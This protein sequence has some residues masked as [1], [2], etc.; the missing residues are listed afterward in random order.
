MTASFPYFTAK[1]LAALC[2]VSRRTVEGWRYRGKRPEYI[3][4]PSGGVRYPKDTALKF[5]A[6]Y[7]GYPDL[8]GGL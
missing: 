1:E 8:K 6:E 5:V 4:L 3:T 7:L 2:H